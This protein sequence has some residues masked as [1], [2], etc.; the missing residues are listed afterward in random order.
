MILH[1]LHLIDWPRTVGKTTAK[2]CVWSKHI[3][4]KNKKRQVQKPL[5]VML[6]QTFYSVCFNLYSFL[7]SEIFLKLSL[8][9]VL[10][11]SYTF[12]FCI[13]RVISQA[14][15]YNDWLDFMLRKC[16]TNITWRPDRSDVGP[17]CVRLASNGINLHSFSDKTSVHFDQ[18]FLS[19]IHI[20]LII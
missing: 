15:I 7:K 11:V 5:D 12:V 10:C 13:I 16:T 1:W 20:S 9:K 8:K 19:F 18:V 17:K 4:K 14:L 2:S 6:Y 3:K